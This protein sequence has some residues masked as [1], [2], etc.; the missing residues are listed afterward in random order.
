M[1]LDLPE[2]VTIEGAV[3]PGFE[4][5]LTRE[6]LAFVAD[7]QR[8]FNPRRLELLAARVE[9]QKRLDAG[10]KPDFLAETAAIRESD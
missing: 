8:R 6:A 1:A 4:T 2:G 10:E 3:L 9:R 7:L 5:V